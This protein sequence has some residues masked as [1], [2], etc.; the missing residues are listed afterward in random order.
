VHVFGPRAVR[1]GLNQAA[2]QTA[3]SLPAEITKTRIMLHDIVRGGFYDLDRKSGLLT[4][5]NASITGGY[6]LYHLCHV[7]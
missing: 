3:D 6:M 4:Y 7:N 5:R 2:R 1:F